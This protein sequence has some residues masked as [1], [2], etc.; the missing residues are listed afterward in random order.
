MTWH[1]ESVARDQLAAFVQM[2]QR[3]GGTIVSSWHRA[4]GVMV[5][6]TTA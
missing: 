4:G 1:C 6:W 2:I 3:S 5:T